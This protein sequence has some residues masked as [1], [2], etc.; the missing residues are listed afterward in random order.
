MN[1]AGELVLGKNRLILLNN[2]VKKADARNNFLD[3]LADITNY[4]ELVTNE[5]Q[6]VG[7]AGKARPDKQAVQ[8]GAEAREGPGAAS[9]GRTSSW[10]W[11]ARKRSSTALS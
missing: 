11:R 9:S 3:N 7:H 10:R 1:L 8:Q 5:L 4:M 2:M 6:L